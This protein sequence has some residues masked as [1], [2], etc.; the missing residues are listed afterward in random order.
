ML[1]MMRSAA[2]VIVLLASLCLAQTAGAGAAAG[3]S[4][5]SIETALVREINVV[6]TARGLVPLQRSSA[7]ARAAASHSTAMLAGGFFAH[8]SADGS[9]FSDRVRRHLDG[10][11]WQLGENL[12]LFGPDRPSARSIVALWLS[13]PGHRT[14]LLSAQW[15]QLGVAVRFAPQ[16]GGAFGG[17]PTW[18]VTLD[19]GTRSR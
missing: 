10:G 16:A 3:G 15:R 1:T 18:V 12:A 6:R 4:T 17:L 14:N 9:S 7:L 8:E 11:R 13:S 19:V 5:A 2:L